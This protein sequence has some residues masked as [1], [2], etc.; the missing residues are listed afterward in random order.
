MFPGFLRGHLHLQAITFL[1]LFPVL[2]LLASSHIHFPAMLKQSVRRDKVSTDLNTAQSWEPTSN[3]CPSRRESCKGIFS[4]KPSFQ[5]KRTMS[6]WLPGKDFKDL[7]VRQHHAHLWR[8]KARGQGGELFT[9]IWY[10][11]L[12]LWALL[13]SSKYKTVWL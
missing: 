5:S 4:T 1:C 8:E 3:A 10:P 7:W 2:V 9:C 11:P 12:S 6:V 13:S